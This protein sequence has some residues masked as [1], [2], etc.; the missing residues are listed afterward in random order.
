[1]C[2]RDSSQI[3]PRLE[4]DRV[5]DRS[6]GT[7]GQGDVHHL[8]VV[9]A[10]GNDRVG[11]ISIS[12]IFALLPRVVVH[13]E[14]RS[15][16]QVRNFRV[17]RQSRGHSR[18]VYSTVRPFCMSRV[19]ELYAC[20]GDRCCLLRSRRDHTC[21]RAPISQVGCPRFHFCGQDRVACSVDDAP[22]I[23]FTVWKEEG[24]SC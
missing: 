18:V 12:P 9:G 22:K 11:G 23:E 4:V 21:W 14:N 19:F 7:I 6:D 3:P 20:G 10:R 1:M 13:I 15:I 16:R 17:G 2:I 24:C 5:S 8:R